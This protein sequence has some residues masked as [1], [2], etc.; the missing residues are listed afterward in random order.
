[1]L[2]YKL[3]ISSPL[4]MLIR[5]YWF[6]E[7]L[8]LKETSAVFPAEILDG[9]LA[10]GMLC[11]EHESVS[12]Q[13][14]LTHFGELLLA[15]DSVRRAQTGSIADLV[16]GVSTPT[17][18]LANCL[19]HLPNADV[20]DLGA[21]CG[22]LALT[23]SRFARTVTAADINARALAFTEFN[24]ALN[25]AGDIGTR[26]GDRF[27][28]VPN[29]RFDL[30]V[31]NPP[32]FLT[33]NPRLLYT[34]NPDELD[35]FV[36]GLAGTAPAFLKEHG[37]FQML[38]EWVEFQT[39]RWPNRLKKWV[40]HSGCDV[41]VLKA[42]EI[43]PANYVL[44]R[45]A[46]S[47][48][49]CGETSEG[50]LVEH[51]EYFKQR[52]VEKIIGGLVTMRRREG[53]NWFLQEEMED[54]PTEPAGALLL[55]RFCAQDVL[56]SMDD[57]DLLP[58]KPRLSKGVCLVQEAVQQN[59]AWKARTIYLERR[60]GLIRRLALDSTAADLVAKF[61]GLQPLNELIN[62]A[63]KQNKWPKR[64][65][66]DNCLRLVRKLASLGL[67]GFDPG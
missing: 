29:Q 28:A 41:L 53:R 6:G 45:A 61:D 23:A 39:E 56:A 58:A 20:L 16:L 2:P 3:D 32:F 57:P 47:A 54:A 34:E 27:Q 25:G 63:A 7:A 15:C 21:G 50:T 18:V 11:G 24:A 38:C 12:P 66:V 22:T 8:S 59:R 13:C 33:P 62:A 31:C 26:C 65:A 55:E 67:I 43:T 30:I 9:M 46:E 48:S 49:L 64:E 52:N 19:I 14:M 40:E 37:F 4:G 44:K 35:S 51:I 10:C 60:A 36:E 42:Y 5:L 1:M 17:S